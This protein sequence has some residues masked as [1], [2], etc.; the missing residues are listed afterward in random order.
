MKKEIRNPMFHWENNVF[1]WASY[2]PPGVP[3]D[4]EVDI[5]RRF[6][7]NAGPNR[8]I[9]I[10][11]ATPQLRD[12]V[13]SSRGKIFVADF[14]ILML[15]GMT[16]YL[17]KTDIDK[18]IWLKGNWFDLPLKENYFDLILGDLILRMLPYDKMPFF[19]KTIAAWLKPGKHMIL[20]E[21]FINE[22]LAF[23]DLDWL[24]EDIYVYGHH[25]WNSLEGLNILMWQIFDRHADLKRHL[26]NRSSAIKEIKHFLNSK[27]GLNSQK[28][29][30]LKALLN[31]HSDGL[32]GFNWS[33]FTEEELDRLVG[34][35]FRTVERL[36]AKDYLDAEFY[37]IH[38]L[39][40]SK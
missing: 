18:E 32:E 24:I 39:K 33:C 20:R 8:N 38:F 35:N 28:T 19:L 27:S 4:G 2:R 17:K 11:G 21:H 6:L 23:K 26:I 25:A 31:F 40:K 29:K 16:Q 14:S 15:A 3:S 12:I 22:T 5:C 1:N 13:A 30:V 36:S 7:G 10:L 34:K 9:L 37:P